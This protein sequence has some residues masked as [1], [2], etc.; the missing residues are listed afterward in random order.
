MLIPNPNIIQNIGAT[1][2]T[3]SLNIPA[4]KYPMTLIKQDAPINFSNESKV[5]FLYSFKLLIKY[6]LHT[7]NNARRDNTPVL[8]AICK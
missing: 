6:M 4:A 8:V 3:L 2:I 1:L 7:P 5:I